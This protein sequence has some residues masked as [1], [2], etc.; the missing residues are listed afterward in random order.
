MI[1]FLSSLAILANLVIF[2]FDAS[3]EPNA[4]RVVDDGVMGGLSAGKFEVDK[5]GNGRFFG[6]V[7]LANNG[8]FSSVRH[9]FAT[10]ETSNYTKV[11]LRV[12]GDGKNYQFRLKKSTSDYYSYVYTFSTTGKWQNI[13]IPFENFYPSF[14][15]MT[16]DLPNYAPSQLEE[17]AFLIANK[18]AEDFELEID[19]IELK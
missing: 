19:T 4:W 10:K 18:V 8:G 1:Y 14:R 9:Q 3:T 12:K 6:T 16:L 17:V 11:V 7:S 2:D 5:N 13:E 15:G